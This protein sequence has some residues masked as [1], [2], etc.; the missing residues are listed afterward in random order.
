MN[1]RLILAT[2]VAVTALAVTGCKQDSSNKEIE[3][4]EGQ[5]HLGAQWAD[6]ELWVEAF[7]P[8][9]ATCTLS[10]YQDN[11]VVEASTITFKNCRVGGGGPMMRPMMPG[12][13]G[14]MPRP[15]GNRP[16]MMQPGKP[17]VPPP[18]AGTPAPASPAAPPQG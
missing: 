18:A 1:H 15:D 10:R 16:G 6:G 2:A 17:P 13:P 9:T 4:P 11:K 3:L 14:M 12:R 7:D 8:K 5:V